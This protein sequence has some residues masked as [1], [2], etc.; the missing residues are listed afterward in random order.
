MARF[1]ATDE[2]RKLHAGRKTWNTEDYYMKRWDEFLEY[3]PDPSK[4]WIAAC[5]MNLE[6]QLDSMVATMKGTLTPEQF[7]IVKKGI[8]AEVAAKAQAKLKEDHKVVKRIINGEAHIDL[9][10]NEYRE[11][12]EFNCI[13]LREFKKKYGVK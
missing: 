12:F 4:H 7:A 9:E 2:L 1:Y 3:C 5:Y 13:Q 8:A 10:F 11:R 6:A